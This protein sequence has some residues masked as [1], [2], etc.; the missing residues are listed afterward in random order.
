M[1]YYNRTNTCDRCRENGIETKLIPEIARREY[2]KEGNWTG[3]WLCGN[4]H[5]TIKRYNK[6]NTCDKCREEDIETKISPGNAYGQYGENGM[7]TGKWYCG[8]CYRKEQYK[9]GNTNDN[10][11]NEMRDRR[12]GNLNPNSNQAKGD[13]F[14]ELTCR[15]RSTISTIPVENLNKKLDN[16]HSPIDHSRDSEL[17]IPQTQGRFYNARNGL[18]SFGRLEREWEKEFDNMICY[19]ASKDGKIIERLYIFPK[20]EIEKRKGIAITK[21]PT[22]CVGNYKI[23]WYEQYRVKDEE[24]LKKVNNIWKEMMIL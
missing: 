7:R 20:K 4:T 23:P 19:C 10:L 11:I 18:W 6:T 16:Y 9:N 24:T 21:N 22:D 3:K 15:W 12:T 5:K 14:E 2:N 1:R 13:N 8:N 17:G